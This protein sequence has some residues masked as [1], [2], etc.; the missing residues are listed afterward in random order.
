LPEADTGEMLKRF[1]AQPYL[2][3]ATASATAEGGTHGAVYAP[4]LLQDE[5][6]YRGA[7]QRWFALVAVGGRLVLTVPHAFLD[8]RQ[9]RLPVPG[10]P[11]Q[12]RLYTPAS[13]LA[14]IEEA[15]APNSYR[16][17]WL[18]DRDAGYDYAL[19]RAT[20]PVGQHDIALVLERIAPP[21]WELAPLLPAAIPPPAQNFEPART[22]IETM[23]AGRI[24]RILLLKLDH[25]GDFIMGV[26]AMR[27]VRAHFP[28][29]HITLV[30]GEWNAS[31]ARRIGIADK[32]LTF[33]AFPR[34]TA[35][36]PVDIAGKIAPFDALVGAHYDLA[37]DLR[38]FDDTR[39]LLGNVDAAHKAGIGHRGRHPFLDIFLPIDPVAEAVDHAWAED[40]GIAELHVADSRTRG[41]FE[42][43]FNG[44]AADEVAQTLTWG[45]YRSL[46]PG[47][48][49]FQPFVD[50]DSTRAGQL[51]YDIV[52]D[53]E[54][55][56]YGVLDGGGEISLPFDVTKG[57]QFEFRLWT[58][59]GEPAPAF[60]FQGGRLI[61]RGAGGTLHQSET[62][63]LLVEL[64]AMRLR[65]ANL[66]PA[67]N[68]AR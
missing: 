38:T 44:M 53:V 63:M 60:R 15:L 64:T 62:L 17:R 59:S 18:A 20:P 67:R 65:S 19:D 30:V 33:D 39:V 37:I 14:E 27:A 42:I 41:P 56:A 50:V 4:A 43:H 45:P 35:E 10:H 57:G 21:A 12:V 22:R 36:I 11:R 24:C 8:A 58:V 47:E 29:A 1:L 3:L 40:I 52:I 13:L 66:F 28:D 55:V 51:A 25:L 16:L 49:L 46:V 61:K 31:L 32:V 26:P 68:E 2:D 9:D 34:N 54:R 7:L 5:A 23:A 6:D 48:Y